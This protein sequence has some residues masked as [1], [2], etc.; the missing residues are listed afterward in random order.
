MSEDSGTEVAAWDGFCPICRQATRF[1]A[2]Y[3]WFRDHLICMTCPGGSIPRER[4]LMMVLNAVM[5][6][7]RQCSIHESSPVYRGASAV[8]ARECVGY[9]PTQFFPNV[10]PGQIY[11]GVRC[12]DLEQQTFDDAS[13]DIVVT[14]DV[15]EHLFSP[16]RAHQ[17]I[18]R[19]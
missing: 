12:E 15:M 2:R 13:F 10:E 3:S 19:T 9:V 11:N 6:E 5:P 7:W 4:A 16:D 8:L 18:V 1:V 17:E 14:Q